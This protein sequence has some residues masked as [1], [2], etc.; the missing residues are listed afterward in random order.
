[1]MNKTCAV[2]VTYNRKTLLEQA[3]KCLLQQTCPC[4]ILIVDNASTDGT[5]ELI[6][7][8]TDQRI[9]YYN[10]GKNIGGAGGFNIGMKKAVELICSKK[11]VSKEACLERAKTFDEK[12]QI[13]DYKDLY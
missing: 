4:D 8:F 5:N 1:M 2:V 13:S 11:T 3:V 12:K 7:T 10:T 6:N 9:S